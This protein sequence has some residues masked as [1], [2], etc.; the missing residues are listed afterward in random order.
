[1]LL[2]PLDF[3]KKKT[4]T[5]NLIGIIFFVDYSEMRREF[6][7]HL[8]IKYNIVNMIRVGACPCQTRSM[9]SKSRHIS[10]FDTTT[11]HT[12]IHRNCYVEC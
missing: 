1:M 10:C 11:N 9:I 3:K 2:S 12:F 7:P 6:W 8:G 4:I 5:Y